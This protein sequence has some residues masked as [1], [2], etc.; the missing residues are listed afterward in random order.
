MSYHKEQSDVPHVG[1]LSSTRARLPML[2]AL[3]ALSLLASA[4]GH[5][6]EAEPRW[7]LVDEG[8]GRAGSTQPGGVRRYS[9]PRSFAGSGSRSASSRWVST[10]WSWRSRPH[11]RGSE[12]GHHRA[13]K[14]RHQAQRSSHSFFASIARDHVSA[15]GKQR[16]CWEL[17]VAL[18]KE[19]AQ[20]VMPVGAT[21]SPAA[22]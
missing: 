16:R 4:P 1:P 18:G 3:A 5:A 9:F 10:S 13:T 6:Q 17:S 7:K 21:P 22:P 12:S 8:L 14:R 20:S 2:A 11:T 15:C 19:L